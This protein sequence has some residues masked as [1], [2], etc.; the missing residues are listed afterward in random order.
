MKVFLDDAREV[1]EEKL[2]AALIEFD[3]LR[4]G[5]ELS[6]K[7][8]VQKDDSETSDVKYSIAASKSVYQTT[9]LKEWYN[10][11]MRES[12]LKQM[13]EFKEWGLE[14]TLH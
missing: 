3:A 8:V 7:Y 10:A 1:F 5:A 11:H 2:E 4:V 9:D 12:V 6:A 13:K 14:W